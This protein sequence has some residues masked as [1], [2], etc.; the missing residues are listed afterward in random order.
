VARAT[1]YV[2]I[3]DSPVL[4]ELVAQTEDGHIVLRRDD[5]AVAVL[6]A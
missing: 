1:R 2:D 5:K 3:D 6:D 4:L